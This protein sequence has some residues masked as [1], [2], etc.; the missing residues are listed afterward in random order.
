VLVMADPKTG[1]VAD[2]SKDQPASYGHVMLTTPGTLT[3]KPDGAVGILVSEATADGN[4]ELRTLEY[5][6][7][8]PNKTPRGTV[9]LAQRGSPGHTLNVRIARFKMS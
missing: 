5:T 1:V 7:T 2:P 6:L 9:F 3:T 4:R 8:R